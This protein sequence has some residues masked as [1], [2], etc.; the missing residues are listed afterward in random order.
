MHDSEIV[1]VYCARNLIEAEFLKNILAD[2]GI[3]SRVIGD[4]AVILAGMLQNDEGVPCLWVR[5][6][7][8]SRARGILTDFEQ[9]RNGPHSDNDPPATWKCSACGEL[10]DDEFDLCWN[11]Q[12]P[13]SAY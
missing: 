1:N 3:E 7:D 8:E 12:N 6:S 9:R 13:R 5:R 11:C 10:V 4:A 2:A